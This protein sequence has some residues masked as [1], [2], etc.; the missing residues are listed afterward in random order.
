MDQAVDTAPEPVRVNWTR[1]MPAIAP[2]NSGRWRLIR[3][4][5]VDA[6]G[7]PVGQPL[8]S[9][10]PQGTVRRFP[11]VLRAEWAAAELNRLEGL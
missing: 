1:W 7:Q 6:D 3:F 9:M 11:N 2:G 10:T 8:A 5:C 4:E